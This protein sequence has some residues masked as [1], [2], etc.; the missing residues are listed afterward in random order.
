MR[1]IKL[2]IIFALFLL[3]ANAQINLVPDPYFL[4]IYPPPPP[5]YV[6]FN[7][8]VK[9]FNPNGL[10][11][12]YYRNIC[13]TNPCLGTYLGLYL[14][15][16]NVA[17]DVREYAG[18]RLTKK[19]IKNKRYYATFR[20]TR[21]GF[22]RGTA[23]SSIGLLFTKDSIKQQNPNYLINRTPQVSNHKDRILDSSNYNFQFGVPTHFYKISSVFYATED[24][25]QYMYIGNF[26]SDDSTKIVCTDSTS[27][28]CNGETYYYI[29]EV[30]VYEINE[31]KNIIIEDTSICRGQTIALSNLQN[32]SGHT[33][34]WYT[35]DEYVGSKL[36]LSVKPFQ[37][38]TYYLY[39]TDSLDAICH[40]NQPAIDSVTVTVISYDVLGVNA[41]TQERNLCSGDTISFGI[42][43]PKGYRYQWSPSIYLNNDTLALP[44]I[45]IP[46]Y[47]EGEELIYNVTITN[48]QNQSCTLNNDLAFKIVI[49]FCP[50]SLE[51]QIYIPNVFS[52]NGDGEN[53]EFKL[54]TQ[55]IKNLKAAIYNRWG[56]PINTI[57]GIEGKWQGKTIAGDN[58]PTGIYYVIITAEGMDKK[59]YHYSGYVHLY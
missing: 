35:K 40:C 32:Q 27:N 12:D 5:G 51:P 43:A 45:Q 22:Q 23:T 8:L 16:Q 14:T 34:S 55:N 31:N 54:T 2:Y 59:T 26:L 47:L 41:T 13:H 48:S 53:D 50:D 15:Q 7:S 52:P 1:I 21:A 11:P 49:N 10:S 19:L 57:N 6:T 28:Y 3:K 58:A 18:T 33:Y 39:T 4:E 36:N 38:T 56:T 24:D 25:Y 29:K 30:F 46:W 20:I 9:W 17:K 42:V 44:F 37:T